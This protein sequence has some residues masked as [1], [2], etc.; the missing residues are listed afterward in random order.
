M[1]AELFAAADGGRPSTCCSRRPSPAASPSSACCARACGAS[2]STRV[3][4]D[5]QRHDQLHPHE[6]VRGG[7]RLRRR[8]GVR[9]S[10]SATPSA[11]PPP[12]SRASTPAPRRRSWRRSRSAH[13][14]SPATCTTRA[15]AASRP[16]TSRWPTASAT[17][18]SCSAIAERRSAG[19]IAVRVHPAMVPGAPSAG[20][21]ARQLQRGVRR[22]RC[23]RQPHV[24]RPR[25]RRPR[26]RP[27]PCSA[28][29]STPPSTCARARTARWARS[30][31]RHPPDRRDDRPSTTSNIEVVDRPG[32]LHAVT[33]VFA[34]PRRQHPRRM[35]QEGHGD[36]A[37]AGVHHPR[38]PRGRRAGDAARRCATS[39]WCAGS[40]ACCA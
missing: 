13:G 1:G 34:R 24:L 4:G 27:A 7:R 17:S 11:T 39:T 14:S 29:S 37:P 8:T 33:G 10:A 16:T 18:S 40:A 28:T 36:E 35:E 19:D 2:R 20:Q 9:R 32:V 22:R 38:G 15:S 5:R 6:D 30:P 31:R 21:R 25:R 12:T 26:R 23:R 3:H